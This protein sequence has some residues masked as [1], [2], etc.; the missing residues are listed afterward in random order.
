MIGVE[1]LFPDVDLDLVLARFF[2]T[3]PEILP[4]GSIRMFIVHCCRYQNT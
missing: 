3:L 2:R 1:K 4:L